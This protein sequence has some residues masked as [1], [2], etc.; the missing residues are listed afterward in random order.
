LRVSFAVAA[1]TIEIADQQHAIAADEDRLRRVVV[2]VLTEAGVADGSVSIALVDDQ[3]IWELN[4][5][6]LAHDYPTDVLSFLLER[7]GPRLEG[8]IVASTETARRV[9]AELGW[10]AGDEL[11][12]YVLHGALHLVGYDDGDEPARARMRLAENNYLA[13]FGV[14]RAA[15][16]P[17]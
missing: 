5:R 9:A 14:S 8:Q 3:A 6:Y 16:E 1:L 7:E 15:S 13:R 17:E 2:A 10:P 4:R 12:L 11:L